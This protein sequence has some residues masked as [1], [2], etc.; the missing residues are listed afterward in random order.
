V[1][2]DKA[3]IP[4]SQKNKPKPR[5]WLG[6]LVIAAILFGIAAVFF[7]LAYLGME[8]GTGAKTS[9]GQGQV[10]PKPPPGYPPAPGGVYT[11]EENP[12]LFWFDEI[13]YSV[14][15]LWFTVGGLKTLREE[16]KR[17]RH[18]KF[19]AT[20]GTSINQSSFF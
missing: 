12:K 19:L 15:G 14:V 20:S 3:E 16:Y 17:R 8:T 9:N 10:W 6:V 18:Q 2:F 11:R 4:M 13:M 1:H 5:G 7:Y